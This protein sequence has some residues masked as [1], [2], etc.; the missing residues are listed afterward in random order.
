MRSAFRRRALLFTALGFILVTL[1]LLS[2][3]SG[4]EPAA[5]SGAAGDRPPTVVLISLDG[6][7]PDYLTRYEAPNLE[8]LAREG[9]WAPEGMIP[10]FPTK[11][12]PNH[13]SIVTGLYPE[14]HGIVGNT[15]YDPDLDAWFRISDSDAVGDSRWWG[16][17]PIWVTAEKQGQVSGTYFWVGSEAAI[18]DVRP[19]YW[20]A[21]DGRIGGLERVEEV[22]SWLDLPPEQRPTIVMLYFSDV[23]SQS[24]RFGP[25]AAETAEAVREVDGYIGALVAGLQEQRIFDEVNRIIVSDHG[26]AA[27]SPERVVTL[28]EYL[29]P[30]DVTIVA[31]SPFLTIRPKPGEADA[32]LASLRAMPH[33]SVYRKAD[34]PVRWHYQASHRIPEIVGVID[35]G[36]TIR[37]DADVDATR[38]T[39]GAHGYDNEAISM[40]ALFLAHGPA[41]RA[42]LSVEPFEVVHLYNLMTAILDLEP[43][44]NDGDFEA[45]RGFLKAPRD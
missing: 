2:R 23:D 24:H 12:F 32:V 42:P 45:V 3:C 22:L 40:R 31:L 36:W 10:A 41:F 1:V 14:H 38:Y 5:T 15:I 9:V 4:T 33:L 7:R 30:D 19:T 39:G 34:I 6:F 26:M 21:Y 43:A 29:N 37:R 18:Q 35:D 20:K 17:E 16:G 44:P 11:T 25:D 27:Q 8:R 28:S 13:Y